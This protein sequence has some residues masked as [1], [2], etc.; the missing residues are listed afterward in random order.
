VSRRVSPTEQIRAQIDALFDGSADLAGALEKV[1]RLGAQLIIQSAMEAEVQAVLGR[2]RY[3]RRASI[4][5]APAGSRNGY[6]PVTVKT[7]HM[8]SERSFYNMTHAPRHHRASGRPP[9]TDP[10]CRSGVLRP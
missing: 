7:K 3:Q 4:G 10:G 9:A 8:S 1:A 5:D 6:R 2:A